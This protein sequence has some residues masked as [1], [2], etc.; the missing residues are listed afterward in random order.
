MTKMLA[1]VMAGGKGTRLHP[2]TAEHAKPALHFARGY[3]IVDFVLSNLANSGVSQIYVLVQ[4]KP[5][6]L[7]EYLDRAWVSNFDGNGCCVT[8]L[9][10]GDGGCFNGTADAV[11]QNLHL[12][13]SHQPDLVAVFA[14]DHIY[15]MDVRQMAACHIERNASV[16]VAAVPVPIHQASSF[17]VIKADDDGLIRGFQEKPRQPAG[18]PGDP[19]RAYAS[20][21]NYLFNPDVLVSLLEEASRNG[22]SDFGRHV[23]PSLPGRLPVYAYDFSENSVPGT[24]PHEERGYWRDVGS[25]EALVAA[26]KDIAG[27]RPRFS[28]YNNAWPLYG[29]D[30]AQPFKDRLPGFRNKIRDKV[31]GLVLRNSEGGTM[32]EK[33]YCALLDAAR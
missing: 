33:E 18:M 31:P 24:A 28:L 30:R 16:S 2:L 29:G 19:S 12:I 10:P 8:T 14:A 15:R 27:A 9:V 5:R 32:D 22:G 4:Y 21:G 1:L 26:Q 6:S 7:L 3:R 13:E 17:G 25:V 11:H 20:M 23:L